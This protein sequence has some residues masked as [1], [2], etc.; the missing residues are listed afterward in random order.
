MPARAEFVNDVLRHFA[1]YD[2]PGAPRYLGADEQG[3]QI[4][5]YL[6]GYVPRGLAQPP[7]IWADRSLVRIAKLVRQFHDLTAGTRLAGDDEVV[8]HN[9]LSPATTVYRDDGAGLVP[10]AFIDW[11]RA[12]P[13]KRV[14]DV[15]HICW[16]FLDLGPR[17]TNPVGAAGLVRMLAD[18]YG[19]ANRDR[20]VLVDAILWCLQRAL[21]G[22]TRP[23]A[24]VKQAYDW[25]AA[26]RATL[27]AALRPE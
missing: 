7:A 20:R 24:D 18:S 14:H 13:G 26:H 2:W 15:A 25:V 11:D 22:S 17:R 8:C 12:A 16:R 6:E 3:R 5:T 9:A 19:L 23:D 21:Y 27:D 1:R 4:L 10:Y